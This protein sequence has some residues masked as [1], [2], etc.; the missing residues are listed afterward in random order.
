MI[1]MGLTTSSPTN[2]SAYTV[3]V[4]TQHVSQRLGDS[5]AITPTEWPVWARKQH[6]VGQLHWEV[7]CLASVKN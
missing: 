6:K 5:D 1:A 3:L 7:A 2:I 4:T